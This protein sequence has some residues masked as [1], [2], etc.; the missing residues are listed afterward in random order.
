MT[1]TLADAAIQRFLA[2]RGSSDERRGMRALPGEFQAASDIAAWAQ[3][4]MR[5][6]RR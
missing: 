3:C 6:R 5:Q 2:T 4:E 1:Q